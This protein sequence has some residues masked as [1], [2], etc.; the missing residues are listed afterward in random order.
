MGATL[1]FFSTMASALE[2]D[3]V[4]RTNIFGRLT[5]LGKYELASGVQHDLS[6]ILQRTILA[7]LV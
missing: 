5:V 2:L 1:I 7:G 3:D 6:S 4:V